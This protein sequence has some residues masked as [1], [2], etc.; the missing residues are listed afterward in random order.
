M[1]LVA[2]LI[3]LMSQIGLFASMN[4][5]RS[6]NKSIGSSLGQQI[7]ILLTDIHTKLKPIYDCSELK[8]VA[9]VTHNIQTCY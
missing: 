3:S 5:D 9:V 7:Q 6:Y 8:V 4:F 1:H 2:F